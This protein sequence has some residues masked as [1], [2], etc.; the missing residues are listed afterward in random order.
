MSSSRVLM[1]MLV[2]CT[3]TLLSGCG[4]ESVPPAASIMPLGNPITGD[5]WGT[6]MGRDRLGDDVPPDE[7]NIIH[8][9]KNYGWPTCFGKNIHDTTFDK[10]TYV[11]NPCQDPFETASQL[12]NR[13]NRSSSQR[14]RSNTILVRIGLDRKC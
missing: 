5:I 3:A 1:S 13:K 9:G 2:A 14:V 11:R 10:N 8:E 6:E 4:E 12:T 7:I